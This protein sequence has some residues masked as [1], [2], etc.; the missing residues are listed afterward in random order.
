MYFDHTHPQ[1]P[2]S[3]SQIHFHLPTLPFKTTHQFLCVD[4]INWLFYQSLMECKQCE[5][6]RILSAACGLWTSA[7]LGR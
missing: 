4:L 6:P 5:D 3:S 7:S 1:L 2:L